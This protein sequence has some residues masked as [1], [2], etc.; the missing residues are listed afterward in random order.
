MM[1]AYF[2]RLDQIPLTQNGKVDRKAL[3]GPEENRPELE[4]TFVAPQTVTE[5]KLAGIWAQ[6]LNVKRVGI[7]DD[8]FEMGGASV[9]AVQVIARIAQS[10]QVELPLQTIF[11]TPTIAQLSQT[12]EELLIAEIEKLSDEEAEK[13]LANLA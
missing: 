10:F 11:Q 12:I 9:P 5:S 7:H 3:P 1:P 4:T 8:F 13:L 6:T 2:V